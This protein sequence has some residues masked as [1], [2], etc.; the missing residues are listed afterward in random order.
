MK[1]ILKALLISLLIPGIALA[2]FPGLTN[3][4]QATLYGSQQQSGPL[5][6]DLKGNLYVRAIDP[7]SGLTQSVIPV[8]NASSLN[9]VG[10]G[11]IGWSFVVADTA[12]TSSTTTVINATTHSA[13]VGDVIM[14]TAGTAG[15][16]KAWSPVAS[17]TTNTITI[18][19]ALPTTPANG[20]VFYIMR[21]QPVLAPINDDAIGTF[22][23]GWLTMFVRNELANPYAG[24]N[25]D[26]TVPAATR[27]GALYVEQS[28][29]HND[30]NPGKLAVADED[31]AFAASDAV[32]KVG[33]QALSAI[34]Q[35][36][37]TTGDIAPPSMDLGNRLVTTMAPAGETWYACSA[38]I[39]S[40][41][42]TTLKAAVASNRI[43]VTDWECIPTNTTANSVALTDGAGG[44][45]LSWI[46][47]TSN[48][49]APG[50]QR[51]FPTPKRLTSNTLLSFTTGTAGGV[52]CCASGYISTI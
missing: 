40:A 45:A 43:Y 42:N 11:A 44:T 7:T 21:P 12:E 52:R 6:I 18:S 34:A 26:A 5:S 47:T 41:T 50:V 51:V 20:D 1:R 35:S 16:I 4:S 9:G 15:N 31:T 46:N 32:V 10:S 2:E 22:S 8:S 36:V 28:T 39:T 23:N 14:F 37:G 17:V 38:E 3:S 49:V 30:A 13:R 25:G 48:A 19:N 29:L 24:S 27:T 33:A